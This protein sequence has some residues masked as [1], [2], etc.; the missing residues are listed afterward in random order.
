IL[1]GCDRNQL[2]EDACI[3]V[4]SAL[5]I[6][7]Q[8]AYGRS[9]RQLM[10][11]L[12]KGNGRVMVNLLGMHGLDKTKFIYQLCCIRHELT[13]PCTGFS[14]L[15]KVKNRRSHGK[16]AL[17]ST[18]AGEPLPSS[19]RIRQ[20]LSMHIGQL[21]LVIEQIQLRWTA[22]L[23]EVNHSFRFRSKMRQSRKGSSQLRGYRL[24]K[25]LFCT[26]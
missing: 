9:S 18:H 2:Y 11:R 21:R 17:I 24:S 5:A 10:P 6:D 23:K 7:G 1:H 8:R 12:K 13:H 20:F 26:Q 14:V 22:T 4:V 25:K 15:S 3:F 16:T 19:Y